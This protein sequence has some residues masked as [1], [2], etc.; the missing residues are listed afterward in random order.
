[1]RARLLITAVLA[2]SLVPASAAADPLPVGAA[3]KVGLSPEG[4]QRLSATL[5]AEVDKGRMPGAVIAIA[6][7]GQLAYFEAIGTVDP[8]SKAPMPRDAIFSIASMTKPMVS[9]AV[10][11]RDDRGQ[12]VLAGPVGKPLPK[13]GNMQLAVMKTGAGGKTIGEAMAPARQP[14]VQDLLRHTAGFLYGN[15]GDTAV[16]KLWP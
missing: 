6:R 4:L 12:L 16:H 1:M 13:L 5:K 10:I 3:E 14:T 15:R 11:M 8:A 9:L 2:A 7:K